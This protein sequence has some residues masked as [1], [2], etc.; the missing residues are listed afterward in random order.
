MNAP[1]VELDN[2]DRLDPAR[3]KSL[4]FDGPNH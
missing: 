4:N 2:G 3:L 1:R